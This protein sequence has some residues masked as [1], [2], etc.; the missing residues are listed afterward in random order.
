[1]ADTSRFRAL[2]LNADTSRL[3]LMHKGRLLKPGDEL[4]AGMRILALVSAPACWSWGADLAV[5]A[6][7]VSFPPC[8][9]SGARTHMQQAPRATSWPWP[10]SWIEERLPLPLLQGINVGLCKAQRR[11]AR[12]LSKLWHGGL[13]QVL[14][15]HIQTWL[16]AWFWP[17]PLPCACFL[18]LLGHA[19]GGMAAAEAG[20]CWRA[21]VLAEGLLR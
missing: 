8:P 16:Q 18:P 2:G 5:H 11:G 19:C 7:G 17:A 12:G 15:S 13:L 9:L 21:G 3:K 1:M 20:G 4:Q 6:T 14:L 10:L